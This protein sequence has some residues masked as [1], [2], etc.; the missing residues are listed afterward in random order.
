MLNTVKTN[1]KSTIAAVITVIALV[2]GIITLDD[3]YCKAREKDELVSDLK[4]DIQTIQSNLINFK[5]ATEI[6]RLQDKIFELGLKVQAGEATHVD[7]AMLER[8]RAQLRMIQV[9][10]KLTSDILDDINREVGTTPK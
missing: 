3:R 5:I 8:Y 9:R 6:T 2:T 4:K 7:I 1:P 10:Y